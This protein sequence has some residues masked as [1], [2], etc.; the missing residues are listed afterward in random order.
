MTAA[1]FAEIGHD[2]VC[3]DIDRSKVSLL[4][5]GNIPFYEPEL[6]ELVKSGVEQGRLVFTDDIG[7]AV[8]T[9]DVAFIAVGTP[10]RLRDGEADLSFVLQAADSVIRNANGPITIVTKSTVPVGTGDI[11]EK[12]GAVL[13]P[14][15][16]ISVVSNPEFLREG[17]A[18]DDVRNPD[19][20]VVGANDGAGRETMRKV[21]ARQ[22]GEGVAF[23]EEALIV[24][25]VA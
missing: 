11:I 23:L 22:I 8:A 24:C 9:A 6:A 12:R 19:R 16:A 21:Y 2:V 20:I 1:S 13:R 14:G 7:S 10:P 18:V 3:V 5:A 17:S 25:F 4:S 15:L